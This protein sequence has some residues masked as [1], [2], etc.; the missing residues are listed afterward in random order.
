MSAYSRYVGR[1][2]LLLL[3][4]VFIA[5]TVVFFVPRLVP[6]EPMTAIFANWPRW[7]AA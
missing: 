4:T 1:R 5:M 2:F 7:A 6:G 3:I